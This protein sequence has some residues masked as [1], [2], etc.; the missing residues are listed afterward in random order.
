M[1]CGEGGIITTDNPRYSQFCKIFRNQG[2]SEEVRYKYFRVG[3]NY[4]MTEL[5]AA[6]ALAQLKKLDQLNRK[7]IQNARMLTKGLNKV[8]G[9]TVPFIDKRAKHVFHQYTIKCDNLN[10]KRDALLNYLRGKSIMATVYYPKPLHLYSHIRELGY[11]KGDFPVA[12]KI[13][14]QVLSLPVHPSLKKVDIHRIVNAVRNY[15]S[16]RS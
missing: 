9:I 15:A 1:M 3:Y 13:A 7:R 4:R 12:E 2:M 11:K 10:I 6:L 14:K 5:E 16:R 8:K